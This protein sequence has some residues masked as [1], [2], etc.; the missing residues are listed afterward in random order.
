MNI[1]EA[2]DRIAEHGMRL[3]ALERRWLHRQRRMEAEIRQLTIIAMG[4][5]A[6]AFILGLML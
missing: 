1:D 2:S 4:G 3:D 5:I 6:I